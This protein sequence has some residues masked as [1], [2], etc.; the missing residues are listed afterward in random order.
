M[1][2]LAYLIA[3]APLRLQIV[4]TGPTLGP[5]PPK[6]SK[7]TTSQTPTMP[8]PTFEVQ[9][10]RGISLGWVAIGNRY[11]AR[12]YAER[13]LSIRRRIDPWAYVYRIAQIG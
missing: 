11:H 6:L 10:Y 2:T 13:L 1:L 9:T 12:A 3:C 7:P 8:A 4:S 5:T